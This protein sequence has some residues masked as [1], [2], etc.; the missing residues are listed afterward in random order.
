[1]LSKEDKEYWKTVAKISNIKAIHNPSPFINTIK[2][3]CSAPVVLA[4]GR[5]C[6]EKDFAS[7]I[8]IWST[9]SDNF[10]E[11]KLFIVGDGE[12]KK[13]LTKQ[14]NLYQLEKSVYLLPSTREIEKY[15]QQDS[16][17]AMTSK[18]EGFGIVLV[19]AQMHGIPTISYSCPC[20]PK[21]IINNGRD[22]YLIPY[23]DKDTF[24]D[25]LTELMSNENLRI[26][27]GKAAI[28]NS[29]RFHIDCIMNQW[30][31]LF[32]DAIN[33]KL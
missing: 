20:G 22:G 12:L 9:V 15:Y 1:M 4:A 2:S 16:I 17:Y 33:E 24:A 18:F 21:E 11:W 26:K 6:D 19:E 10:P 13:D 14:I 5:F 31:N 7:L 25:K 32:Q 8:D 28:E 29:K 27:M 3:N 23:G 30:V